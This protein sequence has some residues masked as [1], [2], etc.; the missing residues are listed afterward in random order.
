MVTIALAYVLHVL[1]ECPVGNILRIV[2]S[3]GTDS[4]NSANT[5]KHDKHGK[6]GKHEALDRNNNSN[7]GITKL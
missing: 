1:F 5:A 3:G 4:A 6:H 7:N 2:Q